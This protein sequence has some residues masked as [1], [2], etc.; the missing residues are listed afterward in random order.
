[1]NIYIYIY[2]LYI[3]TFAY[4]HIYIYMIYASTWKTILMVSHLCKPSPRATPKAL[5][6]T[7]LV[8]FNELIRLGAGAVELQALAGGDVRASGMD[9]M[10]YGHLPSW[11]FFVGK[12]SNDFYVD[13]FKTGFQL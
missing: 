4:L 11:P 3:Y 6:P 2:I 12:I 5:H 10:E 8:E 7:F 1:M 13:V 9:G